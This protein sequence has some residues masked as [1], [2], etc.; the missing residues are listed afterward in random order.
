MGVVLEEGEA[1]ADLTTLANVR[2]LLGFAA[3]ETGDD[4]LIQNMLIPAASSMIEGY[5]KRTFGTLNG[6]LT[7]DA[8]PPY[9]FGDTLFL[10]DAE[11]TGIYSMVV[12][13]ATTL[14][15]ADFDLLPYNSDRKFEVRL[16]AGKSWHVSSVRGAFVIAGTLGYGSI[17]NDVSYAATRLAGWLYQTRDNEGDVYIANDTT[18]IPAEAPPLVFKI[19]DKGRYVKDFFYA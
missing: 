3:D 2:Q 6:T 14:T 7:L 19:L 8:C 18:T 13:A 16:K 9:L 12:N 15:S 17:P 4:A 11:L 10:R 1:M 5:C